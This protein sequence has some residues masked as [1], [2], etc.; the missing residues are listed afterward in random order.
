ML[1]IRLRRTGRT[2]KPSFRVIVAE[3]SMPIYGR[4]VDIIGNV[5]LLS[6][7]KVIEINKEKALDWMK[8]G[9][10]P[11]ETVARL[12]V[13][14]GI[15]KKEDLNWGPDK[16]SKKK[17]DEGKEEEKKPEV[18]PSDKEEKAAE[19]APEE[20]ATEEKKPEE[21]PEEEKQEES[22]KEDVS[23]ETKA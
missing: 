22:K 2:K 16:K 10:Q 4:F 12:M 9:A 18:A 1:V 15:L 23:E 3:K 11:S 8:K 6:N 7:P 21:A 5:N 17:K 13:K 14:A 19:E 20:K